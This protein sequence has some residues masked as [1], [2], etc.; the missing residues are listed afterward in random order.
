[1]NT[2]KKIGIYGAGNVGSSLV[3]A[4]AELKVDAEE[5]VVAARDLR[6]AEAAI[7]DLASAYPVIAAKATSATE[8]TGA[9]DIV[10][11]T[12]GVLPHEGLSGE[13]LLRSN[14]DIVVKALEQVDCEKI[15]VIGTPVDI[16]TEELLNLPQFE[17]KQVIGFG[18]ELDKARA[19]YSLLTRSIESDDSLYVVGEHGPR[20]IPVYA[21]EQD[22]E[23]VTTEAT[24]VLKRIFTSGIARNLATGMQLARLVQALSGSEQIMCVCV[25]NDQYEGLSITWPHVINETGVVKRVEITNIGPKA[26]HLLEELVAARK[27]RLTT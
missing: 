9:F 27:S 18:G 16:L 26:S 13:E 4:L 5:I 2:F 20:A 3:M 25:P 8:L 7:L 6:K 14:I 17:G 21:G 23:A 15:I 22:Y 1:M 11:V 24:T 12:A 10:V 19:S